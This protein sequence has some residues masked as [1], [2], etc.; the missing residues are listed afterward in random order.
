MIK[1]FNDNSHQSTDTLLQQGLRN[2]SLSI[3][4]LF[5]FCVLFLL[6]TKTTNA[7]VCGGGTPGCQTTLANC[8]ITPIGFP[9]FQVADCIYSS[10]IKGSCIASG[11][12]CI[13]CV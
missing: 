1:I 4:G 8:R 6:Q 3:L 12:R 11:G 9:P 7:Q 2:I 10:A 13:G 5:L